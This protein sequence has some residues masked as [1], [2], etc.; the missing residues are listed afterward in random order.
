MNGIMARDNLRGIYRVLVRVMTVKSLLTR[1][2]KHWRTYHDTGRMWTEEPNRGHAILLLAEYPELP[3]SIAWGVAGY[4]QSAVELA[5]GRHV[6][7]TGNYDDPNLWR[8]DVK[9]N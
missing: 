7:V 9:W 1:T 3:L 4:T 2:A 8:W 5:G 6:Q